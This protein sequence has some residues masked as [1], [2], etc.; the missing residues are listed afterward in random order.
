MLH[1]PR[2]KTSRQVTSFAICLSISFGV[3]MLPG[4]QAFKSKF[5]SLPKLPTPG[6]LAFWK[7]ESDVVPPPP[8]SRHLNP[9]T[10]DSSIASNDES[11]I[12][13]DAYRKQIDQKMN[14][15][16]SAAN[17]YARK[18]TRSPY[19][20]DSDTVDEVANDFQ[21]GFN[22]AGKSLQ[23]NLE[24]SKD[25]LSQ[26]GQNS[27]SDAQKRFNSAIAGAKKNPFASGNDNGFKPPSEMFST[28][29]SD[30]AQQAIAKAKSAAQDGFNSTIKKSGFDKSL[31][32]V[33]QSLY[34]MNGNLASAKSSFAKSAE[35]KIDAARQRFS[36]ALG[37]V[38]EGARDV[39]NSS[40]QLA[41]NLK[42]KI[43]SAASDVTPPFGKTDN[44]FKP[45]FS[46]D[47][48]SRAQNV[49][50]KAKDKVAGLASGF[51]F[52]KNAPKFGDGNALK[53]RQ[54]QT[55]NNQFGSGSF[56]RTR[57]ANVTPVQSSGNVNSG[58]GSSNN[59]LR[60]ASLEGGNPMSGT[61]NIPSA[62]E[63]GGS[64]MAGHFNDVDIPAKILSGSG[65][66][67]PGSVNKVR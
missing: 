48:Q 29:P 21:S 5:S 7:K 67:A 47:A 50:G 66:Y 2:S 8:P 32:N 22:S 38:G 40:T 55:P 9:I 23:K 65:S 14:A 24:S 56:D 44:S 43:A 11:E 20:M 19:S 30:A 1:R 53:P 59:A 31:A 57:V 36:S 33:N 18:N 12:D 63:N 58:F 51:D 25:S 39:V 35:S 15:V 4:C 46:P 10:S 45:A 52:P 42:D 13:I 41:G 28:K 17:E 60:T 61:R 34:D 64:A 54:N 27:L 3:V 6:D 62:Y 49:L 37:T 26:F 16:Q